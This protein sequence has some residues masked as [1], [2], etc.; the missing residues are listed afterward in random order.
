MA[1]LLDMARREIAEIRGV[2][3]DNLIFVKNDHIVPNVRANLSCR[4][5]RMADEVLLV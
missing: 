2:S 3:I 1:D 5:L 4:L